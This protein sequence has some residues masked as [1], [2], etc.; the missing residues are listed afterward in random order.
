MKQ[1]IASD[2]VVAGAVVDRFYN[3]ASIIE[4]N[5]YPDEAKD[6]KNLCLSVSVAVSALKDPFYNLAIDYQQ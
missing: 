3:L 5:R 2:S 4:C 1:K 6:G